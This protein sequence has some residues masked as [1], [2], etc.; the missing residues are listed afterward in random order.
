MYKAM[1]GLK[2]ITLLNED[3]LHYIIIKNDNSKQHGKFVTQKELQVDGVTIS[4]EEYDLH[5]N[6]FQS[7]KNYI[8]SKGV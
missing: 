4:Q 7:F 8:E 6:D 1:V 2:G 3:G 5:S